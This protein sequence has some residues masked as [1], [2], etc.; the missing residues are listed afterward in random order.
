MGSVDD[1]GLISLSLHV[2][3]SIWSL[4]AFPKSSNIPV[5]TRD[6]QPLAW[7]P[8]WRYDRAWGLGLGRFGVRGEMIFAFS[9]R[10][11][12]SGEKRLRSSA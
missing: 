1:G 4:V 2:A 11:F 12:S 10:V 8:D 3:V 6:R 5:L 7:F 9:P